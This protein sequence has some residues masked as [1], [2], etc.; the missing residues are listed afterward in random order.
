MTSLLLAT[1]WIAFMMLAPFFLRRRPRLRDFQPA[2][3]ETPLVS[4]IVPARNEALNIGVCT[5]TL[6]NTCYPNVEI[7][8]VDDASSDATGD[9]ARVLAQRSPMQ[10]KVVSTEPLPSGW[11]GKSWACWT[12][13]QQASGELLLFTDADTRHDD[14]LLPLAV[15]ALQQSG[16]ALI[17]IMPRQLMEGFW[18]RVVLPHVFLMLQLSFGNLNRVNHTKNPRRVIANGQFMLIR[19]SVYERL[20]GHQAVRS[21]VCEDLLLAQRVVAAG[22][23]MLLAHA[24]DLM[25][26]RMYRSLDGIIEGWSKNLARGA[27]LALTPL[28]GRIAVWLGALLL[29]A[30]WVAPI[31]I[32]AAGL[33]VSS[34]AP[35]RLAATLIVALSLTYWTL[36]QVYFGGRPTT[37]AFFP[38]GALVTALVMLR[39]ALRGNHIHWRGRDYE[40]PPL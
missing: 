29:L 19:R 2:T 27:Q 17:T 11:V 16:A 3:S 22:D 10:V 37:S 14:E 7:I 36:L 1:P 15:G 18:E 26:T 6:F 23:R 31:V 9:I 30:A 39:S 38:L 28:I 8:V 25:E 33:F 24:P 40:L 5:A 32:L 4:I 13:Y 34:L 35:L 21:E 20:G 12:G